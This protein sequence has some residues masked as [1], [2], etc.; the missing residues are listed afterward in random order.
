MAEL[1]KDRETYLK[2]GWRKGGR[3]REREKSREGGREGKKKREGRNVSKR[4]EREIRKTK[5]ERW[6]G[7]KGIKL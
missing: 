2:E 6:K 4:K 5:C 7:R 1:M 3:E